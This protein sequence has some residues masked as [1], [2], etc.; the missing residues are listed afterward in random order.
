MMHFIIW[1]LVA[2]G[3]CAVVLASSEAPCDCP[4]ESN[5]LLGLWSQG[6][7]SCKLSIV[8]N[9]PGWASCLAFQL[10]WVS[11]LHSHGNRGN[12]RKGKAL[13]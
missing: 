7:E 9:T 8:P 6:Q 10:G 11:G 1:N 4:P 13:K 12:K 5:P 2:F 3:L